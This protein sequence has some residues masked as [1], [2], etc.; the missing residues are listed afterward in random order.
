MSSIIQVRYTWYNMFNVLLA[1]EDVQRRGSVDVLYFV[2][3]K[4][5]PDHLIK[6]VRDS[7]HMLSAMPCRPCGFHVCYNN[8]LIRPFLAFLH[9]VTSKERKLRERMHFGS[10]LEVQYA[11]CTFG[12][13]MRD[14]G[15]SDESFGPEYINKFMEERRRIEA[16][17]KEEQDR[18][19]AAT[20]VIL[21][22][23]PIDVLCGRGRPYQDFPGNIR[24]GKLVDEHVPLYLETQERLAKTMIAIGIVQ[25]V[26]REGGRFLTRRQDGWE[27]AQNKVARAKISQALRVRALKKLRGE[28][29][30]PEPLPEDELDVSMPDATLSQRSKRQRF[31]NQ[32][33]DDSLDDDSTLL[34][35]DEIVASF[36]ETSRNSPR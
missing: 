12:I 10:P 20:G 24:V 27:L 19:E 16:N 23:G 22:P 26:Q 17:E 33:E 11:L 3:M 36:H 30:E 35:I 34:P 6:F 1:D 14:A 8:E 4:G 9:M 7:H 28:C 32:E 13:N 29:L 5:I 31:S 15:F 21:H 18:E 2:D 25:Q